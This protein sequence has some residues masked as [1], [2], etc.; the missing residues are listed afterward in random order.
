MPY[1]SKQKPLYCCFC[2][3]I[4]LST[5]LKTKKKKQDFK[6]NLCEIRTVLFNC[7]TVCKNLIEKF[8]DVTV[9]LY[10]EATDSET[11]FDKTCLLHA[12]NVCQN[13]KIKIV[14][15]LS[16]CEMPFDSGESCG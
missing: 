3:P 16:I 5:A 15:E 9:R 7:L 4:V 12:Y 6:T 11:I 10:T 14:Y 1:I 2:L 8:S 13:T